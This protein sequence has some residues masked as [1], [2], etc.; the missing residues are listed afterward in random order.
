[1]SNMGEFFHMIKPGSNQEKEYIKYL[2]KKYESDKNTSKD[3]F[4]KNKFKKDSS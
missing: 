1:M 3:D 4:Y 2:L